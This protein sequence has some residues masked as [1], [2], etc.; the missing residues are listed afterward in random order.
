MSTLNKMRLRTNIDFYNIYD[1]NDFNDIYD[2]YD[3]AISALES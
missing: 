3:I 1:F 2:F